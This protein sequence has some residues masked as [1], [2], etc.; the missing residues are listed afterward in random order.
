MKT[1]RIYIDDC[2]SSRRG[3]IR[4][5]INIHT[6]DKDLDRVENLIRTKLHQTVGYPREFVIM[7]LIDN[8]DN[9]HHLTYTSLNESITNAW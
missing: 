1:V 7:Y 9:K 5:I 3:G 8:L 4:D 2:I 6:L